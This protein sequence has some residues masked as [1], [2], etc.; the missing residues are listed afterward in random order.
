MNKKIS[1][2]EQKQIRN[3]LAEVNIGDRVKVYV[4]IQEGDKIRAH[5]FEGTVIAKKGSGARQSFTVRR[6]SFGEGVE[7][8][9][10]RH[11]PTIERIEVLKSTK[12]KRAKIYY[13]R[14]RVGKK[15]SL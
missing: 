8:V 13:L 5:P 1:E 14:G 2:L 10:L 9:F 11:S 4:K 7:K 6:I 12:V 3:D 15:A